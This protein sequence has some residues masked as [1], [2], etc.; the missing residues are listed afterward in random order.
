MHVG[1]VSSKSCQTKKAIF[2]HHHHHRR[3]SN[4]T[5]ISTSSSSSSGSS[6]TGYNPCPKP[7]NQLPKS[8]EGH[9]LKKSINPTHRKLVKVNSSEGGSTSRGSCKYYRKYKSGTGQKG[10]IFSTRKLDDMELD[11]YCPSF[12]NYAFLALIYLVWTLTVIF[13]Q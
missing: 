4:T 8:S 7:Q 9:K 2:A 11:E 10:V 12:T 3:S 1:G 6:F 13:L 5:M